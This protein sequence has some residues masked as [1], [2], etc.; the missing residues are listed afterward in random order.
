M[1]MP[2][3]GAC[4]AHVGFLHDTVFNFRN[5]WYLTSFLL[6]YPQFVAGIHLFFRHTRGFRRVSILKETK[7]DSR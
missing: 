3:P 6:S 4:P 1:N 2:N 7:M 5:G